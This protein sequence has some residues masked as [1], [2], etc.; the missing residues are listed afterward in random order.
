[1]SDFGMTDD[2]L[3]LLD[4]NVTDR[5]VVWEWGCGASTLFLAERCKF[6]YAVEHQRVWFAKL[7]PKIPSNVALLYVPQ[8]HSIPEGFDGDYSSHRRYVEA[9][10]GKGIDV[11]V[12]DGRAR[13]ACLEQVAQR[14]DY[15]PPD[16]MRVF[17]HDF[18]RE[19]Y[20]AGTNH[21]RVTGGAGN[22]GMLGTPELKWTDQVN[23]LD[24][25]D[26]ET[27]RVK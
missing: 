4:A 3:Q 15:G 9:Y 26:N 23:R 20:N 21:W 2:E 5:D 16:D 7:L 1:M 27:R 25:A 22:L 18:G 24:G 6:V 17:L 19:E 13:V 12:I 11:V 14:A 10:N 8:E